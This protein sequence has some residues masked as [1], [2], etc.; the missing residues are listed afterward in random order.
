MVQ[1]LATQSLPKCLKKPAMVV[2]ADVTHPDPGSQ[3]Q[4][5]SIAAVCASVDPDVGLF[6]TEVRLQDADQSVEEIIKLREMM[7]S[8]LLKFYQRNKGRKPEKIIFYRDGV[9]E[10][11]FDMVLVKASNILKENFT[12]TGRHDFCSFQE[13]SA[14]QQACF[15]LEPGYEPEITFVVAQKRK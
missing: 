6:N 11:Q 3:G 15:D 1:I 5:P 10:G 2:G 8:L 14:I 12:V 4:K 9:S 7:S 13:I